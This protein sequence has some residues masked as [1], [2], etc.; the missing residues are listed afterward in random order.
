MTSITITIEDIASTDA[1]KIIKLIA[2]AGQ[3]DESNVDDK[4]QEIYA[5]INQTPKNL[6]MIF[7]FEQ[8]EYMNS[9][10]IGYLTDWFGKVTE[11]GGKIMI[12][13]AKPN[14]I[15]ILQVIGLTQLIPMYATLEEAKFAVQNTASTSTTATATATPTPAEPTP[16]PAVAPVPAQTPTEAVASVVTPAEPTPIATPPAEVVPAAVPAV[17][18]EPATPVAP[19]VVQEVPV[20]TP[21]PVETPA[22]TPPP[23]PPPAVEVAPVAVVTP[24]VEQPPAQPSA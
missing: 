13:K 7:D 21:A 23:P 11:G 19:V 6:F 3:L 4:A 10:S 20:S 5:V 12:I 24:P 14:I 15:D 9:K 18:P 22:E 17:T 16:A 8:L 1:T 2:I